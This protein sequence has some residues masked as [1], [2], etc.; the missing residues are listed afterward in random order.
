MAIKQITVFVENRQGS[1]VSIT[2][3]LSENNVNIRALSIADTKDF[4]ILRLIV[5]D[6]AVAEKTLKENGYLIKVTDV[7]GVK[8]GDAPGKLTAALE[9]LDRAG[10]N[11]EYLYAFMARTEKHAYVVLRVEDNSAAENALEAAGFHLVTHAD[12]CKL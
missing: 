12:I 6:E 10:I 1:L 4:G 11:M 5:N 2:R 3:A 7:V 9:V 8:I